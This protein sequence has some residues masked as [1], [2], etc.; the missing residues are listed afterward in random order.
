MIGLA[1]GRAETTVIGI[2]LLAS[3]ACA[4]LLPPVSQLTQ[5][6]I[7]VLQVAVGAGIIGIYPV[8]VALAR[9]SLAGFRGTGV[10]LPVI[11]AVTDIA[12]IA[13]SLICAGL[14]AYRRAYPDQGGTTGALQRGTLPAGAPAAIHG[15]TAAERHLQVQA[16]PPLHARPCTALELP[17]PKTARHEDEYQPGAQS[18][19][20]VAVADPLRARDRQ[21]NGHRRTKRAAYRTRNSPD[22][23]GRYPW[24][25]KAWVTT[26]RPSRCADSHLVPA[27]HERARPVF[28][29]HL[30]RRVPSPTEQSRNGAPHED[31]TER[32]GRAITHFSSWRAITIR[33]IWFVPS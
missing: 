33:W 26:I 8:A 14:I 19:P 24:P 29:A 28:D 11:F 15:A 9:P 5:Q 3:V 30:F 6:Q 2:F 16:R 32:V 4:A 13:A 7:V 31:N 27:S 18:G 10:T 20:L 21:A 17:R 1:I 22:T 23:G 12:A 25:A